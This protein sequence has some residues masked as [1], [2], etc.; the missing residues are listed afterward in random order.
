MPFAWARIPV[1]PGLWRPDEQAGWV[2]IPIMAANV[3]IV[4]A[5]AIDDEKA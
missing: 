2:Q 3:P 1:F 5:E 4:V